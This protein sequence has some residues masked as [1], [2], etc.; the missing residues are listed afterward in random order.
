MPQ[1]TLVQASTATSKIFRADM[2]VGKAL[3]VN[4]EAQDVFTNHQLVCSLLNEND[5]IEQVCMGYDV[6]VGEFLAALEGL[7]DH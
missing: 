4:P 1:G 5:T 7:F 2:T 6:D 3:A